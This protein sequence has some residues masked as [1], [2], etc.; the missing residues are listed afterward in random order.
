M[1]KSIFKHYHKDIIQSNI[2][3]ITLIY[4][5]DVFMY[6]YVL[7]SI[8]KLSKFQQLETLIL[9]NIESKYFEYVLNQLRRLSLLSSLVI[10]SINTVKN[11]YIIYRQVFGLPTLQYCKLSLSGWSDSELLPISTNEY[12]LIEHLI[13]TSN[14]EMRE[15]DKLLSYVPQLR[16]LSVHSFTLTC[17]SRTKLCP[18]VLNYLTHISFNESPLRFRYFEQIIIDLFPMIQVLYL[19]LNCHVD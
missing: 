14:I 5:S 17:L 8:S 2:H 16:R 4:C 6:D 12:S 7:S 3:R 1:S 10:S 11:K 18:F 19:T 9:D 15:L 13:I